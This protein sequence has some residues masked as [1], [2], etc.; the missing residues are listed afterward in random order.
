MFKTYEI[1][2]QHLLPLETN[3]V[4]LWIT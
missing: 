4:A 2:T 1:V 3:Y